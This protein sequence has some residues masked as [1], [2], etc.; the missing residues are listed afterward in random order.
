MYL[1]TSQNLQENTCTGV[2]FFIKLQFLITHNALIEI[3]EIWKKNSDDKGFGGAILMDLSI[4]KFESDSISTIK[5]VENDH[6][7]PNHEMCHFLAE[8]WSEKTK[9]GKVWNK[10]YFE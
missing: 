9:S 1:K 3:I 7:N 8:T 5:W 4:S 2:S 10:N 6:K